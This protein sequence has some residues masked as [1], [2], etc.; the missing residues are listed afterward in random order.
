MPF[1]SQKPQKKVEI[2]LPTETVKEIKRR[3]KEAGLSV[4]EYL[5]LV[6]LDKE[7]KSKKD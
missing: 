5:Q 3:A 7:T 6:F 2:P 1:E 4:V